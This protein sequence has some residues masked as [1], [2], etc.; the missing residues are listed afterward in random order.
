MTSMQSIGI[1]GA[2]TMGNG[3]AQAFAASGIRVVLTDIADSALQKAVATIAGSYDRLIKKEKAT[4]EQKAAALNMIATSTDM[5][6]VANCDL[7]IEAATEN[8]TL[9]LKIFKQLDEIAH[10]A[11]ILASNSSPL[12]GLTR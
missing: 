4:A 9:K 8:E 3:I 12:I 1:V 5:G 10:P 2:G 11:A 6:A 7:I